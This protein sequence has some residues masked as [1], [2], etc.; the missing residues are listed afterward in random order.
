[1]RTIGLVGG[2]ASG[3]STVAAELAKQGAVVL[4]ADVAAHEVI[5]RPEVKQVLIQRWGP[6]LLDDAGNVDRAVVASRVFSGDDNARQELEFLES[7]LHPLIRGDFESQLASLAT[8]GC[9][10]AVIDA[11]LLLEAG[12]GEMCDVILFVESPISDRFSRTKSRNWSASEI[13]R[14]EAQQMTIEEKR[15][16]ST[17][18]VENRGSLAEL[19]KEVQRIWQQIL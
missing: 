2:I 5:N 12:W 15:L 1:M 14:R 8:S 16:K 4:D 3:K 18:I 10:A 7:L 17:H 6:E 19:S 11:P 9:P 13:E